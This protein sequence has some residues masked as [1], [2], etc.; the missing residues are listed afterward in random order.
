M[1]I[2]SLDT[3]KCMNGLLLHSGFD[4]FLFIE[5]EIVTF[6]TFQFDGHLKKDFFHQD[7]TDEPVQIERNFALWKEVREFCFSLIKGKRTPLGFKLV[8]S[9]SPPNIAHLLEREELP[10]SPADVQGLYLNFKFNG[11]SLT[12]TTGTSMKLFTM[13][14]S[15]EQAWD[16][17]VQRI[18]TKQDIPFEILS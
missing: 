13:D 16:K 8:L 17:M 2:F 7:I 18:F 11:T 5:G 12:C 14:K 6:C 15:L 4:S 1:L 10:F 9:L 3:K